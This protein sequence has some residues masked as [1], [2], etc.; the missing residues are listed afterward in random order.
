MKLKE[1][2]KVSNMKKRPINPY[3]PNLSIFLLIFLSIELKKRKLFCV[4]SVSVWLLV[5]N[6]VLSNKVTGSGTVDNG[7][8]SGI[9][10]HMINGTWGG[11]V[12]Y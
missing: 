8:I 11:T 3:E 6:I 10:A 7:S 12:K 2:Q 4:S 5:E 9:N 1:C